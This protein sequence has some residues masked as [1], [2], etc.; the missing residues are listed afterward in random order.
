MVESCTYIYIYIYYAITSASWL[1]V[2][3]VLLFVFFLFPFRAI[4]ISSLFLFFGLKI[5]N[6]YLT[7]T[8]DTVNESAGGRKVHLFNSFFYPKIM[9]AGYPGIRR[10][11]KKVHIYNY[12]AL[13]TSLHT[14]I[15][16]V[17]VY[18]RISLYTCR[19]LMD[20]HVQVFSEWY[21]FV[22]MYLIKLTRT[23]TIIVWI[24]KHA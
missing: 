14:F 19:D 10:W 15:G 20:A 1:H 16:T 24:W 4:F 7:L 17:H 13:L 22:Y 8:V 2:M 12:C 3:I 6:F 18:G 5:I 11:T 23:W 9:S 21:W